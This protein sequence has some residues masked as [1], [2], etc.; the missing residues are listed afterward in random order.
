MEASSPAAVFAASTAAERMEEGTADVKELK[1]LA[2]VLQTLAGLEKV[3][4]PPQTVEKKTDS[5]VRVVLSEEAEE[6][7]R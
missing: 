6:L 3:L 5:T 4:E 2:A 7:S 1:E